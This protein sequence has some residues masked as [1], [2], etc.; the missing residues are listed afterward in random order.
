MNTDFLPLTKSLY[1][2]ADSIEKSEELQKKQQKNLVNR[3][4]VQQLR[5]LTKKLIEERDQREKDFNTKIETL[6]SLLD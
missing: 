3:L 6:Q 4:F 2:L 5:V 1:D